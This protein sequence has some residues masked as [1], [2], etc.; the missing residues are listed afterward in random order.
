MQPPTPAPPAPPAPPTVD[1]FPGPSNPGAAAEAAEAAAEAAEAAAEAAG[2]ATA[3]PGR[4]VPRTAQELAGLRGL[5]EE[6]SNQLR[7]TQRRRDDVARQ[8]RNTHDPA[9]RAGL[10]QR[11][12]VL[13]RRMVQLESDIAE[14]GRLV[15]SASPALL[16]GREP[17]P[18][19][20]DRGPP[21][22]VI[23]IIF[24]LGVLVPLAIALS[25]ILVRRARVPAA[26]PA[27][28]ESAER[29]AR[30]EQAVEAIAIEVERVS[31]GQRF[32]TRLLAEP[33][34]QGVQAP[35]LNDY[36]PN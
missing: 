21:E 34:T 5:R 27:L 35:A 17:P 8:V 24:I 26:D 30:L 10:E 33:R 4:A 13:D 2:A 6:L 15:T 32:V 29:L 14:T 22:G 18:R 9:T 36:R 12:A 25:R 23:A 3:T 20:P 7:S 19:A 16:A 1:P 28:R 31:E 11:L